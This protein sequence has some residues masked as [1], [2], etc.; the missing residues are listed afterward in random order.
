[1]IVLVTVMEEK[2]FLNVHLLCPFL[3]ILFGTFSPALRVMFAIT[4]IFCLRKVINDKKSKKIV[5][6]K[7]KVKVNIWNG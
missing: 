3:F 4:C 1:M 2:H 5:L 7:R 6:K